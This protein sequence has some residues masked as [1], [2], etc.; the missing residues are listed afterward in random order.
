MRN[1]RACQY[2]TEIASVSSA[3]GPGAPLLRSIPPARSSPVCSACLLAAGRRQ[4]SCESKRTRQR[5]AAYT[6]RRSRVATR[7]L[8]VVVGRHV[9]RHVGV[10]SGAHHRAGA[11]HALWR[12]PRLAFKLCAHRLQRPPDAPPARAR[13]RLWLSRAC[14]TSAS[15]SC[16]CCRSVRAAP[17]TRRLDGLRPLSRA[18]HAPCAAQGRLRRDCRCFISSTT[19]LSARTRSWAGAQEPRSSHARWELMRPRPRSQD[20]HRCAPCQRCA[21]VRA[22]SL[23]WLATALTCVAR[24]GLGT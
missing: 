1:E 9:L 22:S 2:T 11:C 24:A 7:R 17:R 19:Q 6:Q 5:A 23:R 3:G 20:G 12:Q 4:R 14:S 13:R 10:G 15:A 21:G 8:R 18:R 16:S